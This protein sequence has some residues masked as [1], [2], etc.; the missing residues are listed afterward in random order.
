MKVIFT[1]DTW[2]RINLYIQHATGEISGL[3]VGKLNEAGNELLIT[4][5]GIWEQECTGAE[6]EV[7]SHDEMISLAEELIA[8]G[9][10]PEEINV[11]WHSHAAMSSFFSGTD[12]TTIDQWVND[13]FLCAVVGNKKREFKCKIAIKSPI[14]CDLEDVPISVEQEYIPAELDQAIKEEVALKVK[15]KTYV[16]PKKDTWNPNTSSQIPTTYRINN[17]NGKKKYKNMT[18]AEKAEKEEEWSLKCL[19]DECWEFNQGTLKQF[20]FNTHNY[21]KK[22]D[23]YRP[24]SLEQRQISDGRIWG[25]MAP[26]ELETPMRR[27]L[28]L[29]GLED[30]Y[31]ERTGQTL[32]K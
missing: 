8:R 3:G 29:V 21:E 31:Q 20:P 5:L 13:R 26:G 28:D 1:K 6:T 15:P 7:V 27:E 14:P 11:W 32:Q 4:D 10:R 22:N 25:D 16:Q 19:C 9:A 12:E 23:R 24:K 18:P 2:N 17:W 30:D